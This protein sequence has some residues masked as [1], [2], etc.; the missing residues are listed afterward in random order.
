MYSTHIG[1]HKCKAEVGRGSVDLGMRDDGARRVQ[2]PEEVRLQAVRL[3]K[4]CHRFNLVD[5]YVHLH[6]SI[7]D[8]ST[9][10]VKPK[11]GA[12]VYIPQ[13]MTLTRIDEPPAV[14]DKVNQ[15]P[16]TQAQQ[17]PEAIATMLHPDNQLGDEPEGDDK[18]KGNSREVD[19]HLALCLE[20]Q[21]EVEPPLPDTNKGKEI[22]VVQSEALKTV[23][24]DNVAAASDS[25]GKLM[26]ST[27]ASAKAKGSVV[28]L[29]DESQEVSVLSV[30]LAKELS[31]RP[32]ATPSKQCR[33]DVKNPGN[34][35]VLKRLHSSSA[36]DTPDKCGLGSP[37]VKKRRFQD[38]VMPASGGSMTVPEDIPETIV[39]N[40]ND[41]AVED[42]YCLDLE[43]DKQSMTCDVEATESQSWDED[44]V[45]NNLAAILGRPSESIE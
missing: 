21:R 44:W 31:P 32:V 14:C 10:T 12:Q 40:D 2:H 26:V 19:P 33:L 22:N 41:I 35:A 15:T 29:S 36:L 23:I 25:G 24:K 13:K 16:E 38:D 1:V 37:A 9:I 30:T 3:A 27:A 5:R 20:S 8:R 6:L 43:Q 18:G 45:R 11:P 4:M 34:H 7:R 17:E 39:D 28:D 42:P